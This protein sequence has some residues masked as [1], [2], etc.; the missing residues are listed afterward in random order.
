MIK[1]NKSKLA[2]QDIVLEGPKLY[3]SFILK[4]V[5]DYQNYMQKCRSWEKLS[6]RTIEGVEFGAQTAL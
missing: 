4:M 6:K 5:S 3:A 1:N 2:S